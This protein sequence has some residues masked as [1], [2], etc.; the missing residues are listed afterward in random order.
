MEMTVAFGLVGATLD[1][2]P[3]DARRWEKWRPS[4]G[5]CQ[6]PD[7]L[8]DRYELLHQ[9]AY[10]AL[11]QTVAK[12]VALVSPETEVRLHEVAMD[13]PWDFE[14][15]YG[16]LY[17][18]A[19][20]Y[21]FDVETEDYLVHLT[22]GT[23]VAQICFFLLT[24]ARYV[25]ARIVQTSPGS[26][27]DAA[28]EARIIDLDLSRYD[29]IAAREAQHHA[30]VRS[31]LKSGI[32]TRNAAFNALIDEI[33][34]VAI[35]SRSPILLNGPTGAGKSRLARK[36]Y[37]LKR[38]RGQ[39]A[40]AFVEV[41]CA[42]LRG[43]AAASA[44]FGH[45]RGAFTGAIKD[46]GGL[47]READ[48]G[49]L[50]LDEIGELGLD[51]QAMLLRALEEKAF[52]PVGADKERESDFQLIAGTNRDLREAVA[53]GSFRDDLLARIDLWTF[54][55]PGLAERREDIAPNLA[56]ELAG[57]EREHRRQ[58]RFSREA[59]ARFL[60]FAEGADAPWTAN[61]RDL[62]AAVTRM[63]T[64]AP[65]GRITDEVVDGE[66]ARLRRHWRGTDRLGG[67]AL[68]VE[69]LGEARVAALD[70]FDR[71]QLADVIRVCRQSRSLS[72]AGRTLFAESR[73]RRASTNDS[74]RLRKYLAKHGLAW[75]D[76]QA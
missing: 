22:T 5:L 15:V 56:F 67:D 48:G 34:R 33:E 18:V 26:E 4:V 19:S 25:P 32:E 66:I 58:V 42:T 62:N 16:A 60:R 2:A 20:G 72:D 50:F 38:S 35:G 29:R 41:N 13:D 45:V 59:Q 39:V 43:D 17:D 9:P 3:R 55:L 71:V 53:T 8:I 37:E 27:G 73:K 51:E 54:E 74:D 61:F 52:L 24:E 36:I 65:G 1:R 12:D 70:R 21:A 40:G 11:A 46:R 7:L 49:I 63:A 69:V 64:L 10:T 6:Q 44:L 76:V 14:E 30:D 31:Y 47:L 57:F 28:G 75:A 23:H 68:L